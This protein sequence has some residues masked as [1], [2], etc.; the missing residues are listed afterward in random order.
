[1][2]PKWLSRGPGRKNICNEFSKS[3][4]GGATA[5][6]PWRGPAAP[7]RKGCWRSPPERWPRSRAADGLAI[8]M[9]A[10]DKVAPAG[11]QLIER[12]RRAKAEL[13]RDLGRRI[14]GTPG[15]FARRRLRRRGRDL[16]VRPSSPGRGRSAPC[17]R[18]LAPG[19]RR[20]RARG[21]LPSGPR[22]CRP[23]RYPSG[24][25][26]RGRAQRRR[27]GGRTWIRVSRAGQPAAARL[28][29]GDDW[30]VSSLG[31]SATTRFLPWT[32]AS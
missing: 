25:P 11:R 19:Q 22:R 18:N 9:I 5:N 16:R 10:P 26:R 14:A 8:G 13:R 27:C 21:L 7:D 6:A 2:E 28:S 4:T 12:Q 29:R 23:A 32:L 24:P 15:R 3:R 20:R 30:E 31:S 17:R 1:M